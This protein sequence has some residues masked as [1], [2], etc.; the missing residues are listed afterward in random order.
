MCAV[1]LPLGASAGT[2]TGTLSVTASVAQNCKI[3]SSATLA[4]GAYDPIVANATV[5]LDQST[6]MNVTCTS[7][8]TSIR[9]DMGATGN[10]GCSATTTRCMKNGSNLLSY[11]LYKDSNHTTVW[12]TGSTGGLTLSPTSWGASNPDT[13][14][15]YGEIP[16]G[17]DAAVSSGNYTD[18]ITATVNF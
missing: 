16:A 5:A 9:L 15:I 11:E 1:L 4:F 12:S 8:A 13:V 7:G 17:Q 18:S 10:T 14:T 6:T 2:A 3:S